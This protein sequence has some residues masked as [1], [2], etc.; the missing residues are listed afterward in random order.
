MGRGGLRPARRR[1]SMPELAPLNL[2]GARQS[3]G[4]G[5]SRRPVG[6]REPVSLGVRTR[7]NPARRSRRPRPRSLQESLRTPWRS[8][9]PGRRGDRGQRRQQGLRPDHVPPSS[10]PSHA[11]F[12]PSSALAG[13]SRNWCW[14]DPKASL[15]WFYGDQG[16]VADVIRA[17]LAQLRRVGGA[18]L[19]RCPLRCSPFV[20]LPPLFGRRLTV[21]RRNARASGPRS[22]AGQSF[23]GQRQLNQGDAI[24]FVVDHVDEILA[25]RRDPGAPPLGQGESPPG[26]RARSSR[27]PLGSVRLPSAGRTASTRSRA[28]VDRT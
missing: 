5:G 4:T 18:A 26:F 8:G 28:P 25:V 3:R 22:S 12:W 24:D 23:V 17:H 15:D 20:G 10:S 27:H 14:V 1:A 7:P 21:P 11:S 2:G 16:R 19:G 13:A 9:P 6:P